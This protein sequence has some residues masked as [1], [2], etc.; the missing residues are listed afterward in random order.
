[1]IDLI[2]FCTA[3]WSM[4][5]M[6]STPRHHSF[7]P[8]ELTATIVFVESYSSGP[9]V[10]AARAA[11]PVAGVRGQ[12]DVETA[13]QVALQVDQL[14]RRHEPLAERDC[15]DGAR[16]RQAVAGGR[17]GGL[18]EAT[19]RSEPVERPGADERPVARDE[20]RLVRLRDQL[21]QDH[22]ADVL[23]VREAAEVGEAVVVEMARGDV[24]RDGIATG[25]GRAGD[26]V[27]ADAGVLLEPEPG[28]RR[29][30]RGIR[31]VSCRQEDIGGDERARAPVLEDVVGVVEGDQADVGMDAVV[32]VVPRDRASRR[33]PN[34][35]HGYE[36]REE[37]QGLTQV[38][39]PSSGLP[40]RGY[41][42]AAGQYSYVYLVLSTSQASLEPWLHPLADAHSSAATA[43][44]SQAGSLM[45]GYLPGSEQLSARRRL[46][47]A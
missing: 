40:H 27:I 30:G 31:A 47:S 28:M 16:E 21:V 4:R 15:L 41:A 8:N 1:M 36:K 9:P 29:A 34:H 22:E 14:L 3:A 32:L 20:R 12:L 35:E 18:L 24:A 26:R 38:I 43:I 10:A 13:R 44:R 46:S 42:W 5:Y 19:P 11:L 45:S 25:G 23:R 2:Q 6:K 39:P 37:R 33:R 17:E 7:R